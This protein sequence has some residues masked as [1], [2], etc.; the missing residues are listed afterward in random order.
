[1]KKW[2]Y[3]FL[4]LVVIVLDHVSKNW[5]LSHL[6]PYYPK[7]VMPMLNWTLAYNTGAAFSFLSQS[8]HWHYW[9]LVGVS[10][11]MS[12]ALIIAVFRSSSRIVLVAV[13]LIL[14]GAVGNLIDRLQYGYVIDF[15]D[16][17]YNKSHWPVFNIADTA[18]CL[19][20]LL[21]VIDFFKSTPDCCREKAGNLF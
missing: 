10:G 12:I 5:A 11:V 15:I 1:M 8:G 13:S 3:L 16:M 9:F 19:G 17:Y 6:I 14:G 2:P 4:S 7:V 18:V 20:G 21:L